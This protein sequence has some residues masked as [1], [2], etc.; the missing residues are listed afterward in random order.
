MRKRILALSAA[1]ML[2]LS[3][4]SS[5]EDAPSDASSTSPAPQDTTCSDIPSGDAVDGVEVSEDLD[6]A[7]DVDFDAPLSVDE[8][9]RRLAITGD[10]E[11]TKPGDWVGVEVSLYNATNGKKVQETSYAGAPMQVVLADDAL[12]PAL[13]KA[14]ECVPA[15][16]RVVSAS[17]AS[18]AWADQG[19]SDGKVGPGDD[20]V[21]VADVDSITPET[22]TGKPQDVPK[23]LPKVKLDD[24]GKPTVSIPDHK[25]SD[26]FT[27]GVL[28]KGDGATVKD[29]DSV[30]VQ[31][32]G[33][34]WRTGKVFDQSWG[35]A[36]AQF[37]TDQVIPGFTKALVG[38]KVGSQVVAVIPPKDGYGKSGSESA[39]IKGTD[40]LVFVV[41]ILAT[42]R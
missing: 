23:T 5:S 19:S 37:G 32:Q 29:G 21:I 7:P 15:G 42:S 36:P 41:D 1:A 33:T 40:T 20:I 24:D 28:K 18:D 14:L 39:G 11:E 35:D 30:T 8:T 26:D 2:L 9:Q 31:Y 25:P 13:V 16:S 6:S 4:C 38:Q 34:N 10:G 3:G 12:I 22:A 17:P 27:M